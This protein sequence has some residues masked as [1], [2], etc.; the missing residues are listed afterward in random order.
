MTFVSPLSPSGDS[1]KARD[2]NGHLLIVTPLGI[3]ERSSDFGPAEVVRVNIVD[4]DDN[5]EFEDVLL[6]GRALVASLKKNIGAQ[7]LGRMGQSSPKP[8]QNPAWILSDATTD[9][10]AVTKATTY[11]AAKATAG[12]TQPAVEASGLSAEAT[13][14]LKSVLD[15]N[16]PAIQAALAQLAKK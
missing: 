7:V 13:D 6:W 8:G 4:L 10:A 11:L 3:E 5:V 1:V 14:A 16:D 9:S 12:I 15:V 2:L